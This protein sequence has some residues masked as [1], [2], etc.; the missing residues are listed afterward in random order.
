MSESSVGE[1]SEFYRSICVPYA[2]PGIAANLAAHSGVVAGGPSAPDAAARATRLVLE[3][4]IGRDSASS[5]AL[6]AAVAAHAHPDATLI[7]DHYLAK[8]GLRAIAG[9]GERILS[10]WRPSRAEAAILEAETLDARTAFFG[11]YGITR[12]VMQSHLTQLVA[13]AAAAAEGGAATGSGARLAALRSLFGGSQPAPGDR[14]GV[15]AGY[16]DLAA[17]EAASAGAPAPGAA[18]TA[19]R[20]TLLLRASAAG[21]ALPPVPFA[22][23]AGKALG[24]RSCFLRLWLPASPGGGETSVTVHVQGTLLPPPAASAASADVL[25]GLELPRDGVPA[26]LIIREAAAEGAAPG[27]SPRTL[28]RQLELDPDVQHPP[29]RAQAW[30]WAWRL[31]ERHSPGG[32]WVLL[33]TAQARAAV[34]PSAGAPG[35]ADIETL[36]RP[37]RE[38]ALQPGGGSAAAYA[39]LFAAAA[40]GDGGAFTSPDEVREL[41]RVWGPALAAEDAALAATSAQAGGAAAAAAVDADGEAAPLLPVHAY[42]VGDAAWLLGG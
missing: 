33:A 27:P 21:D 32:A 10:P 26:I 18:A 37:V 29:S 31:Q 11:R 12:D 22:L 4:P 35:I 8:P 2:A 5:E 1:A 9:V 16:D 24:V 42:A 25:H 20:H 41:W 34:P 36:L 28:A 7:V 23:Y 40:T 17:S 3:K 15:Y 19:A 13:A 14:V 30:P 6:L 38:A 39:S